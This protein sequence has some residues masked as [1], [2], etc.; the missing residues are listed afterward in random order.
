MKN[1]LFMKCITL[2]A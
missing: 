2:L 1:M